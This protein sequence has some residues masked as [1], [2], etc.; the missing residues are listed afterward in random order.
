[1]TI[2]FPLQWPDG[3]PRTKAADRKSARFQTTW[4]KTLEKLAREIKLLG[5]TPPII[6]SNVNLRRDGFP[7]ADMAQDRIADPGVAVYFTMR[8]KPRVM[9]RDAH[10]TMHE[11]LHSLALT[12][13]AMR[14]IER[15]GGALMM[16]R[17]FE[18]FA[19]LSTPGAK[20]WWRVLQVPANA[21]RDEIEFAYRR[22]ARERHP[23]RGGSDAM[24]AELNAAR[25]QGF[26]E[27]RR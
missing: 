4:A 7:Y 19:A 22:L 12:I 11:N 9:A 5:G 8:N 20:S 15:H 13:E 24:M 27:C 10:P 26:K 3:W 2:A 18:G 16:E 25:E 21:S 14:A 6:S 1:M 23:D 17:A